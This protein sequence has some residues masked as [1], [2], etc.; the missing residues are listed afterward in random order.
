MRIA[1]VALFALVAS[2]VNAGDYFLLVQADPSACG[3]RYASVRASPRDAVEDLEAEFLG[4]TPRIRAIGAIV[5]NGHF[6]F[7]TKEDRRA[8]ERGVAEIGTRPRLVHEPRYRSFVVTWA[9]DHLLQQVDAQLE[10][11]DLTPAARKRLASLREEAARA[12]AE[13][14]RKAKG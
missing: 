12:L 4:H 8:F 2:P 13:R 11:T 6:G 10:R 3:D 7:C 1:V 9:T 14:R 5:T